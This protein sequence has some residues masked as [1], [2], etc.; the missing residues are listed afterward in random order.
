MFK[1]LNLLGNM[2]SNAIWE[3][4][5]PKGWDKPNR[6]SETDVRTKFIVAKY[7]DKIF[8]DPLLLAEQAATRERE[9][10][11]NMLLGLFENDNPFKQAVKQ[12]LFDEVSTTS[13]ATS[14]LSHSPIISSEKHSGEVRIANSIPTIHVECFDSDSFSSPET[15]RSG[16]S[17]VRPNYRSSVISLSD[18]QPTSNG[19]PTANSK[20]SSKKQ[21]PIDSRITS[22]TDSIEE[23]KKEYTDSIE[24]HKKECTECKTPAPLTQEQCLLCN[25][26]WTEE[27]NGL[28][29][30]KKK[31]ANGHFSSILAVF[32][33]EEK[34]AKQKPEKTIKKS[35]SMT[36]SEKKMFSPSL[37]PFSRN[38]IPGFDKTNV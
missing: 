4:H 34:K 2:K 21:L 8:L 28:F 17:P 27:E 18:E 13:S 11:K 38:S 14:L 9:K 22:F 29:E 26:K 24:E 20:D 37:T 7:Q 36:N 10:L 32:E 19:S 31:A 3:A 33:H 30:L 1:P 5:I 35:A 15:S 16:T 25:Y 23:Q 12:L 6:D